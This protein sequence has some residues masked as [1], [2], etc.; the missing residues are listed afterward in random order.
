M[1]FF[2]KNKMIT[3]VFS[4]ILLILLIGFSISDRTHT[5]KAEMFV[6]DATA[7]TQ[8]VMKTPFNLLSF[9]FGPSKNEKELEAKLDML[10]QLEADLKRLE[11]ENEKLKEALDVSSK[12]DYETINAR[13]ISRSPDQW[14]NSFTIDKGTKHG[15]SEGMAVMTPKGL[16]G[17][18]KRANGSSSFVEMITTDAAKKNI[19][20]EI[21][22]GDKRHYGTIQ[23]YDENG[24]TLLVG[25]IVNDG[26]IKEGSKVYTSGL[27][28]IFPEGIIVGEVV[29][30]VNDRY[31]LSKNASV[32]MD[33]DIN[34]LDMIF[35]IKREPETVGEE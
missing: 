10:P 19:S 20:V 13:V 24:N 30:S 5:T 22:N 7:T 9:I 31:G 8:K 1:K 28:G 29:D 33:S 17:V 26:K 3:I 34:E 21:H 27:T 23:S 32:K 18:V 15:V 6:G 14:L 4:V 12:I 2:N 25:N 35:V 11:E 16:I